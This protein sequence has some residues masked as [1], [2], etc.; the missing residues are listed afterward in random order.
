MTSVTPYHPDHVLGMRDAYQPV[1]PTEPRGWSGWKSRRACL[2]TG[3]HWWHPYNDI[4]W[5][6]CQCG[7]VRDG[8]PQDGT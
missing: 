8:R 4:D 5:F 6:C 7:A 1:Q 3:G 2:R